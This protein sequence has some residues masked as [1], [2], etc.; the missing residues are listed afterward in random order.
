M[1]PIRRSK[2]EITE[3][4]LRFAIAYQK[5]A[6]AILKDSL[7]FYATDIG[8]GHHLVA[9]QALNRL[10]AMRDEYRQSAG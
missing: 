6:I 7:L 1:R 3:A 8:D 9:Q 4:K 2:A 10:Q 5:Q